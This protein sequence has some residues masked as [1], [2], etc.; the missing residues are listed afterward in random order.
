MVLTV[1]R[2]T[3]SPSWY[4]S[5]VRWHAAGLTAVAVLGACA[6]P[7][8]PPIPS[9]SPA[10]PPVVNAANVI[11]VRSALPK[12]YEIAELTGP[13]SAASLWGF[14]AGWTADPAQ[15]GTLAD[16]APHDGGARGLSASGVGGTVFIVV[17]ATADTTPGPDLLAQCGSWTMTFVHTSA[18]VIRTDAPAIEGADTVAWGA[19]TRTIV[20]SG[21]ETNARA[22]TAL[23]YLDHHVVYV[24]LVTDPG[25]PHPPLEPGFVSDMLATAVAALR[26]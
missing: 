24:T 7:P 13:V 11:R 19:M 15:C 12:G 6:S 3:T 20:E 2:R 26:G 16:P 17:S 14:G 22:T 1:S 10:A 23:A 25:S 8:A 18:E 9:S 5:G 4:E 21:T